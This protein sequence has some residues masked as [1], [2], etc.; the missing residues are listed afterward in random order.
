MNLSLKASGRLIA[1]VHLDKHYAYDVTLE[2][3]TTKIW[4]MKPQA[5][6]VTVVTVHAKTWHKA[7]QG[8]KVFR[9][10]LLEYRP[11]LFANNQDMQQI[12]HPQSLCLA[13][14]VTYRHLARQVASSSS[15]YQAVYDSRSAS[16]CALSPS[17]QGLC[18][19]WLCL[20]PEDR[21]AC[22]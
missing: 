18:L 12:F 4:L 15:L 7:A 20:L 1:V 17:K 9:L 6:A 11:G 8:K 5:T 3:A 22:Q 2:L 19:Q 16:V 21:L 10:C 14:A 13:P